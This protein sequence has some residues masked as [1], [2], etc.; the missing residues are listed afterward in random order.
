MRHS[1]QISGS[2]VSLPSAGTAS[3]DLGNA[4]INCQRRCFCNCSSSFS[5]ALAISAF[6]VAPHK[7]N[8]QICF[9]T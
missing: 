5:L 6:W 8:I 7:K 2:S 3:P 4:A 1:I 9:S